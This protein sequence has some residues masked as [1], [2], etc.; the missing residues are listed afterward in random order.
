LGLAF[1]VIDDVL[2]ATADSATLGKT[3]GKDAAQDK[4]TFVSLL[5]VDAARAY[6]QRLVRRALDAL[7]AAELTPTHALQS[8]AQR[9]VQRAY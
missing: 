5:G 4:P 6:A 8:L 7:A 2:D 3:A 9:V 1:Q